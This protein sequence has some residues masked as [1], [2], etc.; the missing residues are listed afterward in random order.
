[1]KYQVQIKLLKSDSQNA[2]S[3]YST[4]LDSTENVTSSDFKQVCKSSI[5]Q[6]ANFSVEKEVLYFRN[7]ELNDTDVVPTKSGLEYNLF[8]K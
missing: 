2:I 6:S 3:N 8:I 4:F 1:M 5:P 7:K